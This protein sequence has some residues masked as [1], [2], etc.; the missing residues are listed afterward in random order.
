M[1]KRIEFSIEI[2]AEKTTI[3][4]A[5]WNQSSYR[6]WASVFFEGS[7]AVT[8]NWEEGSKVHFLA[9]DQSGIYSVI[10]KHIPNKIIRFKHIGNVLKGKELPIDIETK[11]W[12]GATEIYSLTEGKNSCTLTVNIDIMDEHLE[13]MTKTFPKALEKIKNNCSWQRV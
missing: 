2:K 12:S 9:P 13:F 1:L 8:D 11:K 10:E 6:E 3:W 7:Y 5:L 4:K